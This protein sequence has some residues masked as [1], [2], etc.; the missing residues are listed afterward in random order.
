[1]SLRGEPSVVR[2]RRVAAGAEPADGVGGLV[3]WPMGSKI[4]RPETPKIRGGRRGE[5]E[6]E[7]GA[8]S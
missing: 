6:R 1:M 5:V 4:V 7:L 3:W 8:A 2:V